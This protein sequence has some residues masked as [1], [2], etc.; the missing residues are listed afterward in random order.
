MDAIT[1]RT[2]TRDDLHTLVALARAALDLDTPGELLVA[3]KLF[4]GP[5]P[6]DMQPSVHVAQSGSTIL[7][8][9]Q[10][11]VRPAAG[12]AWIGLLAV[13][14]Q[15]R[16]RGVATR[17]VEHACSNWDPQVREVEV[18]AIPGNYLMPG[19]DPRYTAALCFFERLGFERFGD[20]VN[21]VAP[22]DRRFPTTESEQTLARRGIEIRR[23]APGDGPLLDAFFSRAFGAD[24][25][26]EAQ[27]ALDQRPATLHLALRDGRVLAFAAHSTQN[28]ALGFFGP[29]GTLPAARGLGLGRVLLLRCLNDLRAAGHRVALIPWVG[30]IGFYARA[31]GA[32]VARVFWRLRRTGTRR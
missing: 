25:R 31:C 17:L 3:E 32:R 10:T 26:F 12:R 29:M 27:L 8:F 7:G 9:V 24:W 21:M 28:R 5:F 6:P 20:C 19:L 14:P 1:L 11:V 23:A 15:H 18:L 16:R 2:A 4:D 22:L 30:P 13:D